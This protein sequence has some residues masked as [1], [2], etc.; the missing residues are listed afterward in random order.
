MDTEREEYMDDISEAEDNLRMALMALARAKQ[1][2]SITAK[3]RAAATQVARA[4]WKINEII[5]GLDIPPCYSLYDTPKS[6]PPLPD[7]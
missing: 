1:N 2:Q 6:S 5:E 4:S 3:M 7:Q